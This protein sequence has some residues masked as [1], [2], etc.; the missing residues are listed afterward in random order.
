MSEFRKNGCHI[1]PVGGKSAIIKPLAM[2]K[3]LSIPVFV[4]CDADTDK[5]QIEDVERRRSEVGKHKNDNRTILNL[6]GYE[7]A[8]EWPSESVIKSN[9]TMWKTNITKIIEQELGDVWQTHLT[10]A[11]EYYGNP[12]GFKKN[13]LSIARALKSA[14]DEDVKSYTLKTLSGDIINFASS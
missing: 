10:S 3:L 11:Y 1:V 4:I 6:L 8:D 7:D 13:P 14:R 2:A 9:L 12:G 5:D